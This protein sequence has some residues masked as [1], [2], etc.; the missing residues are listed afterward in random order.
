MMEF[1]AARITR[2]IV[3]NFTVNVGRLGN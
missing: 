1:S 2:F 3:P